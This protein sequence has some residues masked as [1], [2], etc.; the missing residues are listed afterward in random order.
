MHRM[1]SHSCVYTL[2]TMSLLRDRDSG[3]CGLEM[4]RADAGTGAQTFDSH[5]FWATSRVGEL[6][7]LETV[8]LICSWAF[9]QHQ[10]RGQAGCD[11]CAAYSACINEPVYRRELPRLSTC[12]CIIRGCE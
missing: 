11:V 10:S 8:N 4:E 7:K 6:Q 1:L 9:R 3:Q 2:R 5:E 12:T